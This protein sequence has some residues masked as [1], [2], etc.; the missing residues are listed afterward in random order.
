[1]ET[2]TSTPEGDEKF[3]KDGRLNRTIPEAIK[4]L[5][6]LLVQNTEANRERIQA[7][8]AELEAYHRAVE[9]NSGVAAQHEADAA[10]TMGSIRESLTDSRLKEIGI[11]SELFSEDISK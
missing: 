1:M 10:N 8:V 9:L 6:D 7:V 3:I 4:D 11:T 2:G 5:N